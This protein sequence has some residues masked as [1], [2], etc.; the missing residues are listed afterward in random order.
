MVYSSTRYPTLPLINPCY[1]PLIGQHIGAK[2]FL[3]D[4]LLVFLILIAT[5]WL[6][7]LFL[8]FLLVFQTSNF[9]PLTQDLD[10]FTS[11]HTVKYDQE[12][13]N[14]TTLLRQVSQDTKSLQVWFQI[15]SCFPA[16]FLISQTRYTYLDWY[17]VVYPYKGMLSNPFGWLL[18]SSSYMQRVALANQLQSIFRTNSNTDTPMQCIF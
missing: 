16:T 17:N 14:T 1:R 9:P 5:S 7:D 15:H 11:F 6:I 4:I 13:S 18:V 2:Y 12:N 8:S 3:K 10:N